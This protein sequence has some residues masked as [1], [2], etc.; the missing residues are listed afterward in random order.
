M[1]VPKVPKRFS[2]PFLSVLILNQFGVF[3][4]RRLNPLKLYGCV[5]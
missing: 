4:T 5:M 2:G 3:D 1:V